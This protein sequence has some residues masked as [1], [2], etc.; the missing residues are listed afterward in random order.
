MLEA[1]AI[2]YA[3]RC[4]FCTWITTQ[5]DTTSGLCEYVHVGLLGVFLFAFMNDA[6]FFLEL[7]RT[8]LTH[9][10]SPVD[11]DWRMEAGT[12]PYGQ[13]R[14]VIK[15]MLPRSCDGQVRIMEGSIPQPHDVRKPF[16]LGL[17]TNHW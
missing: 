5:N 7:G 15:A 11:F 9:F 8:N 17:N 13:R 12:T 6:A 1:G 2:V 3:V 14:R 10:L 4:Y 16:Q